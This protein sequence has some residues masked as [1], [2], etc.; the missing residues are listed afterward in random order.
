MRTPEP[1]DLPLARRLVEAGALALLLTG[2]YLAAGTGTQANASPAA[3]PLDAAVPFVPESVWIY[4]PGYWSCFLLAVWAIRDARRYR[5]ALTGLA[6]VTLLAVPFFLLWPVPAPPPPAPL[7]DEWSHA[8]VR[9]LYSTDPIGSTFPSLHVANAT[10]CAAAVT[11]ASRRWGLLAWALAAG[12][13]VSVLTMKQHWLVDVPAGWALASIGVAAA[14][15]Q[16]R[17]DAAV[18]AAQILPARVRARVQ[19]GS[20]RP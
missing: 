16:L 15:L 9:W 19:R 3:H 17:A 6:I 20:N 14:R 12:V 13:S 18:A 5:A 11:G 1:E 4:L 8:A 10:F 2:V 7:G